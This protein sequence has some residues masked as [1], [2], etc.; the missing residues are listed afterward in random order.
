MSSTRRILNLW[1]P[2]L[3]AEYVLRRE[4]LPA[5][6]ALA[7]LRDS[8]NMQVIHSLTAPAEAQG[9]RL[10]Q[11]MRDALAMCPDLTTRLSN[12]QQ[13]EAFLTLLQRWAGQFSPWV[14]C[15]RPD[16]LTI[17]LSGCAHLF[18]GE[19]ALV[20]RIDQDCT[21]FGL[22]VAV[23]VADTV[24]AAWALARY[25]GRSS[26]SVRTGDA[27]D[28]EA[29]ATRSRAAK[30]RHWERG[31]PRPGSQGIVVDAA[32][33]APPG[34]LRQA[35]APLP[36]AALRLEEDSIAALA[37][38]GLRR[39]GDLIGM[40]R[41]AI[42]RRFGQGVLE[43]LDQALG[44]SAEPVS[45]ARSAYHFAVRLTLPEPIGLEADMIAGLDRLLPPLCAKLKSKGRGLRRLRMQ[46][47]RCDD[48]SQSL[49]VTLARPSWDPDRIRPLLT[50]RM[51]DIDA[52]FGIDMIRLEVLVSEPLKPVQ[53]AGH[54]EAHRVA[55]A[56]LVQDS[57][58]DDLVGRLGARI[59]LE[60]ITRAHP[61]QS[62]IPEKTSIIMAA[63]WSE[64]ATDWKRTS[65]PR[66]LVLFG[67]EPVQADPSPIPP[68]AF[69]WRGR[70]LQR[71]TAVG[72]E[73]IAPEWW[74]DD[75]A[76]RSGVRDYWRVEVKTGERLWMFYA[77]GGTMS[78]GWFCHGDFG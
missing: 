8:G 21:R 18:G 77:H 6:T 30:R 51:A 23:G 52:G 25:V 53:H 57:V 49:D 11:P 64:P 24:G 26:G 22:T 35:L 75:P 66:P 16:G 12:S 32:R 56:N 42:S 7:V 20:A 13:E 2:R 39:I 62:Y 34:H 68:Q 48:T 47:F 54:L 3:G 69:K 78:G 50:M 17:D 61:A 71:L 44:L 5:E 67:P 70:H 60:G 73:R 43:R 15:N 9:L 72:P 4:G 29:H 10:G 58:L 55:T 33:I 28:Q 63:A 31:G 45:P 36:V 46:V 59:G 37:R 19:A 14:G 65:P 76:W 27:I 41:A 74:L 38:V 1:F 40:P